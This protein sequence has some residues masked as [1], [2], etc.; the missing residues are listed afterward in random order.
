VDQLK[1]NRV[2]LKMTAQEAFEAYLRSVN[3]ELT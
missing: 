2:Y 1:I 3:Y